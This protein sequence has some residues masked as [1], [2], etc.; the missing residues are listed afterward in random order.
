MYIYIY[1]YIFIYI[2]SSYAFSQAMYG[3]MV[4]IDY[5]FTL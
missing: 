3:S 2:Y 1:I 4:F 5:R